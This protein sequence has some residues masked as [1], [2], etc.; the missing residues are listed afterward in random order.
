MYDI[1]LRGHKAISDLEEVHTRLQSKII[2]QAEADKDEAQAIQMEKYL[3]AIKQAAG[4]LKNGHQNI[5]AFR[6]HWMI[7]I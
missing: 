6:T 7:V 4:T 1:S 2:M 3:R 5:I